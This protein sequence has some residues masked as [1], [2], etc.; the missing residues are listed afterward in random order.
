[1]NEVNREASA[2]EGFGS[3]AQPTRLA[4]ARGPS[5]KPARRRDRAALRG[6]AQHDVDAPR[7]FEPGGS[8]L[9]RE[10]RPLDELS[11]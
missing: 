4:A 10:G 1:M 9:R 11:G 6:A 2:I 3:L 8:D 5:A 7:H